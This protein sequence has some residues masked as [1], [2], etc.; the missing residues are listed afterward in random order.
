MVKFEIWDTAGQE[1]YHSLA[2]MYYRG[3][4]AAIVV[5]DITNTVCTS[6][7]ITY[8]SPLSNGPSPPLSLY[9]IPTLTILLSSPSPSCIM[10]PIF[11][12]FNSPSLFLALFPLICSEVFHQQCL[13]SV[14][15]SRHKFRKYPTFTL[16]HLC[17]SLSQM[18]EKDM[19]FGLVYLPCSFWPYLIF[20]SFSG[21]ETF[22]RAKAWVSELQKQA[23]TNMVIALAGNKAD[24]SA[25][26]AV[27]Y[28]VGSCVYTSHPRYRDNGQML[29][30]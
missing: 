18:F 6:Q 26:R 22:V 2:P 11:S 5:Y 14:N 15:Y 12:L 25:N 30:Q 13:A 17:R 9:L 4:Q 27:E 7:M 1:R 28:T 23:S 16:Y 24:W 19:H 3:A 29:V 8:P 21:Q 20:I 10:T